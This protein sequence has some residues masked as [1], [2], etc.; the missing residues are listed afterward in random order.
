MFRPLWRCHWKLLLPSF[1]FRKEELLFGKHEQAALVAWPTRAKAELSCR[2]ALLPSFAQNC[3]HPLAFWA[4][5]ILPRPRWCK[6]RADRDKEGT[7]FTQASISSKLALWEKCGY[8]LN[9]RIFLCIL[10]TCT[11]YS[12]SSPRRSF[13]FYSFSSDVP[14]PW[15][16]FPIYYH[17]AIILEAET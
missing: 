7:E 8:V 9:T 10:K 6:A 2:S 12:F 15:V 11:W 17:L 13:M 14:R 3:S 1:I 16:F 4:P 5:W